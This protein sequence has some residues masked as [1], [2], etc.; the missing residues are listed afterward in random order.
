[1]S[2]LARVSFLV[3][4][5]ERDL[6]WSGDFES[7]ENLNGREILRRFSL[8]ATIKITAEGAPFRVSQRSGR[9]CRSSP[10]YSAKNLWSAAALYAESRSA[11]PPFRRKHVLGTSGGA[12]S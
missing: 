7:R 10:Q 11:S 4:S 3:R 9:F 5:E 8:L 6:A 2:G 12:S 1:M